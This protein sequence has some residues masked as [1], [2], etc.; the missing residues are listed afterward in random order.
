M[1]HVKLFEQFIGEAVRVE[2]FRYK[3]SHGKEPKGTGLWI[4]SYEKS[5]DEYFSAP[6]SMSYADALKW[7]KG[8][9][10]ED[11]KSTVYVMESA[12]SN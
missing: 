1:K 7:V 9:A 10:K 6:N 11:S 12:D 4:F 2:T 5:G 8:K 3:A